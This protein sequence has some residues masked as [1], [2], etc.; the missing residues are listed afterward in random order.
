MTI[1]VIIETNDMTQVLMSLTGSRVEVFPNLLCT[2]VFFF[3]FP[4]FL[5]G[6]I[7]ILGPQGMLVQKVW[8]LVLNLSFLG[9][10]ILRIPNRGGEG[11]VLRILGR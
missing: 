9:Q 1:L 7:A 5:V 8:G 2:T 11:L 10:L 6:G 4:S 3:L